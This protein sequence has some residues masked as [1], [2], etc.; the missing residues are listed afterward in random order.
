MN[1][2]RLLRKAT[3]PGDRW[4]M[5]LSALLLIGYAG[6]G[7]GQR[8]TL[9]TIH[10]DNQPLNRLAL[11]EDSSLLV[12]GRLGSVTVEVKGGRARLLEYDSP[13]MIGTRTGWIEKAGEIAVCVP[14]GILIQI[15]GEEANPTSSKLNSHGLDGIAR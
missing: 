11:A 6:F 5:A 3:Q 8:G 7:A 13:R 15:Q 9:V 2:F 14:C 4:L 10:R 12:A 1:F